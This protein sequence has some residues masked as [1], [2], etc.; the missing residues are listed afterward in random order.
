[1][2][3]CVC[4]MCA[5][6]DTHIHTL[7]KKDYTCTFCVYVLCDLLHYRSALREALLL[8]NPR[9]I[10]SRNR[11]WVHHTPGTATSAQLTRRG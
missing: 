8:P 5:L 7:R 4:C 9:E 1:M 2:R 3:A 6:M 11:R 10:V